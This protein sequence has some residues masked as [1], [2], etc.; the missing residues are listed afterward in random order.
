VAEFAKK[1]GISPKEAVTQ[2]NQRLT[3]EV[4]KKVADQLGT[5]AL[6]PKDVGYTGYS[7]FGAKAGPADSYAA[8]FTRARQAIQGDTLVVRPDGTMYRAGK[9]AILDADGLM[10]RATGMPMPPAQ[11]TVPFSE[12]TQ[13][14][15]KQ[16]ES[17]VAHT[18]PKSVA[19]AIDRVSYLAG[20]TGIPVDSTVAAAAKAMR[21]EPQ[22]VGEILQSYGLT[23]EEFRTRA[24]DTS[25]R[26][27]TKLERFMTELK[28]PGQ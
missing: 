5:R 6:T 20:R 13:L 14:G 4:D 9:D 24:L 25:M 28:S 17:L 21:A 2:L 3:A 23:P 12:F 10:A 18:D 11:P 26:F 7:G 19:K 16:V 1:N 22:R 8:G 27:M 15:G